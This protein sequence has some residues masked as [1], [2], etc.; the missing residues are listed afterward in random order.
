MEWIIPMHL[1]VPPRVLCLLVILIGLLV[2]EMSGCSKSPSSSDP[3]AAMDRGVSFLEQYAYLDAF[4]IFDALA[5]QHPDWE[6]AHVN[7]GIA[8]FNLQNDENLKIAEAAYRRALEINPRSPQALMCLGI[9]YNYTQ[10]LDEALAMVRKAVDADPDDPH[11]LFHLG[12][13]L[14]ESG[15]PD[16]ARA[17]LERVVRLQPSFASAHYRLMGLFRASKQLSKLEE[18]TKAFRKLQDAKV[19]VLVGNKYGENGKY[20]C[21]I[22]DSAPPGWKGKPTGWTP[23]RAPVFGSEVRITGG[24]AAL[25]RRP[26]GKPL[27]PAFAAADLDGDGYCEL[28]VCGASTEAAAGT[29]TGTGTGAGASPATAIYKRESSGAYKLLDKLPV[30]GVVCAAG[31][32][33]CDGNTDIVLA[34]EGWLRFFKNDGNGK[35]TETPMKV[36]K[37]NHAGFPVRLYCADLDSDWD[38]DIACLRQETQE[39]GKVRSR[40]EILNNNRDGSFREISAEAGL[41]PFGFAAA[42]L[43]VTDLDGD[44]DP[45]FLVIDG[46]TGAPYLFAN[47]R[48]WR[49][50]LVENESSLPRAPGV[51]ATAGGDFDGDG[52]LDLAVFCDSAVHLWRNERKLQFQEDEGFAKVAGNLGGTA[53]VFADLLGNMQ[54]SLLVI[55]AKPAGEER[56][57]AFLPGP[58]AEKPI[59]VT[60]GGLSGASRS[61]SAFVTVMGAE[62]PA[63]LIVYDTVKGASSW[64]LQPGGT[65]IALSLAGSRNPIPDKERANLSAIGAAAEIRAEAKKIFL[66]GDSGTGGTARSPSR[67]YAGLAGRPVADYVRILWPDSVLQSEHGLTANKVHRVDEI[68]RKPTSCPMLFAWNG[69]GFE[70]VADFL[71]VGGLG[72]FELPGV[73]SKPDPSE[74]VLLRGLEPRDGEYAFEILEPLE[75]CTYLDQFALTVVDHPADVS[76]V[77]EE[78]FAARGPAPGFRLLGFRERIFP[79]HATSSG[80]FDVTAALREVDRRYGNRFERDPRFPGLARAAHSIDLDF[81][82]RVDSL[83]GAD[84]QPYL[85]LHGFVEYGYSTSNFAAW[86]ARVEFHAP[87]VRVERSGSWVALREEWGFPAGYPRYMTVDLSGCLKPGDRRLR[88]ETNM[89]IHWDQAF[90]MNANACSELRVTDVVPDSALLS[91]KGFPAEESLDGSIPKIWVYRDFDVLAPIKVFPGSYTR[92]GDVREL[93]SQVDDRFA[94]FGPGDGLSVRVKTDRLPGI[95]EGFRRTLLAK[96]F[97]YCKDT[98]L[99]TAHPDSVEPLPFREMRGYPY[100]AL[101]GD[102]TKAAAVYPDTYPGTPFHRAYLTEWNTRKVEGTF[103][104]AIEDLGKRAACR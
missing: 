103:F 18:S 4:K 101:P 26:D 59:S 25:H 14:A 43:V 21:A 74:Y 65:W 49:F 79:E 15:Q 75:E 12:V 1:H 70:F 23:P 17:V 100:E 35:F 91:F 11:A 104:D 93:L 66:A 53:G 77:P 42:E 29:G 72:Y 71:G 68:E 55:D 89:D 83:A 20:S 80:G 33:D 32:I 13:C 16:E 84:A 81:D 85:V 27:P 45:D 78:M 2:S 22:R 90:L 96:T 50:R 52:D 10:R 28:I 38:L 56:Q 6:A 8:A 99:Y 64:P 67:M 54:A 76:V 57:A 39:G 62:G 9:L 36:E 40:I 46:D 69:R 5:R 58:G 73:Y 31:D 94:I 82:D 95:P 34:G 44:I 41:E 92:Y 30:D 97:G 51:V 3:V 98:D 60:L 61:V 63:E 7:T 102:P 19:G 88:V 86:Q 24:P 87:T 47:D 48:L 37:E